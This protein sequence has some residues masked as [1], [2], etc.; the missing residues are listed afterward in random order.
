MTQLHQKTAEEERKSKFTTN[1]ANYRVSLSYEG[2]A[3]K[4][5]G[6]RKSIADLKKQ[7]AR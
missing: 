7:Y 3:L 5:D 2:M 4:K 6:K 1:M